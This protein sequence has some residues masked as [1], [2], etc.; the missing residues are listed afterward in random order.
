MK[1]LLAKLRSLWQVHSVLI[2]LFI[3]TFAS[4]MA[5]LIGNDAFSFLVLPSEKLYSSFLKK[6]FV[7]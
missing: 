4:D 1:W 7:F 3:L 2:I 5:V 6:V